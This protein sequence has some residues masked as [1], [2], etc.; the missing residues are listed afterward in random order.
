VIVEI[1]HRYGR[2]LNERISALSVRD[3]DCIVWVGAKSSSG[4]GQIKVNRVVRQA[5]RVAFELEHGTI[6]A[7]RVLDHLCRNRACVNPAHLEPVSNRENVLRGTAPSAR[8]A[9]KTHCSRGH[10]LSEDNVYVHASQNRV[11]RQCRECNRIKSR[12]RYRAL[13]DIRRCAGK[14]QP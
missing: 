14:E 4:Y 3:G 7:G 5:H 2:P 6:P 8:N 12:N 9:T 13:E 1:K 11:A 10:E